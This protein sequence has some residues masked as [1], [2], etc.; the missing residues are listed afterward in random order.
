MAPEGWIEQHDGDQTTITFDP[1][2][3]TPEEAAAAG[4]ENVSQVLQS[5]TFDGQYNLNSDGTVTGGDANWTRSQRYG[6]MSYFW[7]DNNTEVRTYNTNIYDSTLAAAQYLDWQRRSSGRIEPMEFSSPFFIWSPLSIAGKYI[8]KAWNNAFSKTTVYR[9]V[10]AT[11]SAIIKETGK[12]SLQQGGVEAKYFAKSIEDAH[13]YGKILYP[14][15]YSIIQGTVKNS[16]KPSQYWYPHIDIGA[17]VFP[18]Q[19]LPYITPK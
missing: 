7:A 4:Y 19:A 16:V 9:A 6:G 5:G 8:G 15:G 1:N 11:E 10:D 13:W 17:Y 14:N 18:K 2:V 12:F 3:N